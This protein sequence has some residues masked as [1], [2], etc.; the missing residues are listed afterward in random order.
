MGYAEGRLL[1]R[2]KQVDS[3]VTASSDSEAQLDN[4]VR[5]NLLSQASVRPL[6]ESKTQKSTA[7]LNIYEITDGKSV[8]EKIDELLQVPE[9][10][11]A[12]PDYKVTLYQS[13]EPSDPAFRYQWHHEKIESSAA[14]NYITGIQLVKV[15]VID[16][17]ARI[18]HPDLSANLLTGWNVIPRQQGE[19]N[20]QPGDATWNNFNDT[21]GH[22]TH[23]AGLVGALGDN[24]RDGSGVAWRVGMLPCRFISDNGAGYVSDAIACMRLCAEEGAHIYTNSWG[25]VGYSQILADEIDGLEGL[26][27]VAAGNDDGVDLD[28][29]PIY[30]AAYDLP[31]LI[32]VAS[33]TWNDRLSG[34]SNYGLRTVHL[35]APGSD[36]ISTIKDGGLGSMSGTSMATPIVSGAASLLQSVRLGSGLEPL[37]ATE[38]KEILMTTVDRSWA[39]EGKVNSGGRLNVYQA[40]QA[41]LDDLN[42]PNL[43][44]EPISPVTSPLPSVPRPD[45]S[46]VSIP[47]EENIPSPPQCGTTFVRGLNASQSTT[48]GDR[49]AS[50]A[51]NGDCRTY[52]N[53]FPTACSS[54]S[55][56][57]SNPWW[58]VDLGSLHSVAAV[59]LTTRSDCCWDAI[60]G[61]IILLGNTTW[62]GLRSH[63]DFVE[64]GR[65]PF[66]D[67]Y[68][69]LRQTVICSNPQNV[70]YVAIYL[71][72]IK[73]SLTLCE[74]DVFSE[75]HT[76]S[77]T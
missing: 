47:P 69:G 59:G 56:S 67:T 55:P 75:A 40:V 70:R 52:P 12:E 39:F 58:A 66:Q 27:V 72:K 22:G 13:T 2:V 50:F 74:V 29:T 15:C 23:V 77:T 35:A 31:N 19:P 57:D 20:P 9:V 51:I 5:R 71:P 11:I 10:D 37:P 24:G 46:N 60:G 28:E 8:Q 45:Q 61:A 41:I 44:I 25:G 18:D 4:G 36:I 48:F 26:F 7:T 62:L 6:Y 3:S 21:L 1:V 30:P 73:T 49:D 16:S 54:T 17:G 43:A 42:P 65:L 14:W 38:L 34:F 76:A 63:S 53:V 64:C 68:R 32:S 33:S